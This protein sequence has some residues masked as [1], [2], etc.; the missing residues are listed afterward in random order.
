M[1]AAL[2]ALVGLGALSVDVGYFFYAQRVLQSSADAAALA[3][4]QEIGTGTANYPITTA[5]AYSSVTGNK[6]ANAGFTVTS[7]NFT[8]KCY[9]S[10]G[11]ALSTNQNP[12]TP[13]GCAS[14]V[15]GIR[16][17]QTATV[18]TFFGRIFGISSL[19]IS[20]TASASWNGGTT[21]PA[22]VAVILDTT[23]SMKNPATAAACGT[24]TAIACA[25]AGVQTLLGELWPCPYST[26]NCG[27]VTNFNV[28]NPVDEAALFVFPP[29]TDAGQ[30]AVDITCTAP[31]IATTY[32]GVYGVAE[33]S[34]GTTVN[35]LPQTATVTG[36]IANAVGGTT[37]GTVLNVT[38]VTSGGL[39][40]GSAITGTG[41]STNTKITGF[42]TGTGGI[43]TYTVSNSQLV[44]SETLTGTNSTYGMSTQG[45]GG[46]E[47]NQSMTAATAFN[48][49]TPWAIATDTAITATSAAEKSGKVLTF[50]TGA[51]STKVVA[52]VAVGDF[53]T[54]GA[55]PAGTTV[56]STTATT[57]TLSN[58]VTSVGSGDSIVFNFSTIISAGSG[59]N[60]WPW[61]Q[62]TGYDYISSVATSPAPGS[63]TLHAAPAAPG[64]YGGDTIVAAPLYQIVPLSSDYRTSDT[65]ALNP[66]S[67]IVKATAKGCLGVP[68]G[69]GT[70]YA[71][72]ITAAQ[73]RL[74]GQ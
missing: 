3:G 5:T 42:G 55:I 44:K 59:G 51:L 34:T 53:T 7:A 28:A 40:I 8:L 63:L 54:P 10:T 29:V 35:L 33:N 47:N 57:V 19:N 4:A 74:G 73:Y 6:N 11:V 12:A 46:L 27:P 36:A 43:G 30:A 70:F 60:A 45:T 1:A 15:N 22:N 50:A 48:T 23:A 38:K 26:G 25:A 65:A 9:T 71:D 64:V 62:N 37:A 69:L 31:Q 13:A 16:V 58:S 72:A 32:S 67:D 56:T 20:A 21:V 24:G 61:W 68:G 49:G 18:P 41:V 2:V 66:V 52:G 14:G 17:T 39:E